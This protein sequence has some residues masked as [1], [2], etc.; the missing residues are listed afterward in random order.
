LS[1]GVDFCVLLKIYDSKKKIL[2]F[3]LKKEDE[4][5]QYIEKQYDKLSTIKNKLC[6]I[7]MVY[8]SLNIES[9]V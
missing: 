7:Y 3:A 1:H 8:S 9:I 2:I 4:I 6:G 5:I